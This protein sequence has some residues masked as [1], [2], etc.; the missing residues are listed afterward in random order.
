MILMHLCKNFQQ[1]FELWD[2]AFSLARIYEPSPQNASLFQSFVNAAVDRH[3]SLGLSIT[4]KVHLMHKHVQWQMENI[5]G[6]LGDK[7]ED[8]IEKSHQTGK[9]NRG[10]FCTVQHL[11]IRAEARQ[12]RVHRNSDPAVVAA[13]INVHESSKRKFT[14]D[15]LEKETIEESR[16]RERKEKRLKVLDEYLMGEKSY[17]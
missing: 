5:D 14:G 8:G 16:M 7:M 12:R 6:G 17:Q 9:R 10:Q 15:Q 2:G 11:Q 13:R 3:V 4:P 1:S